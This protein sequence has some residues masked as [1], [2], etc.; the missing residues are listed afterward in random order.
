MVSIFLR[1]LIY[2]ILFYAMLVIWLLVAIPTFLMPRW[3]ILNIAKYWGLSSIWLMRVICNT[4]FEYRGAEKIPAG[5][6]IVASKH[7]SM[8]ETFALLQFFDQPIF[9]LKREL[10]WIPF[11]GWYLLKAGMI[12]IDRKAGV[13]SLK[14]MT[15]MAQQRMHDGRQLVIF[16]EG[17]RRPVGAAPAYK[18]GVALIYA[19]AGVP[20]IPVALNSGL[21]WPRRTFLRYPGTMVIEFLDPL[22]PGLPR[23][24][25]LERLQTAIEGA[26]DRLVE[27]ARLEQAQLFGRV[28]D[29]PP[30]DS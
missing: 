19:G 24:E 10:N 23:D 27:T 4:R 1:S 11:F 3:G 25:F 18:N 14:A 5:P 29:T 9:I 16:P 7:Q 22:P 2:N 12:G 15:R 6:L 26:T 28:P 13:R 20:C 8:W 17:T 21:F 30:A